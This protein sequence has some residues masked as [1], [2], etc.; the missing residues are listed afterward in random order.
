[1]G[2]KE[3]KG[4]GREGKG[5]GQLDENEVNLEASFSRDPDPLLRE[6]SMSQISL[7]PQPPTKSRDL[8][9]RSP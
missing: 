1:M 3:E 7:R 4:K 8:V 9:L 5:G 2:M 6:A